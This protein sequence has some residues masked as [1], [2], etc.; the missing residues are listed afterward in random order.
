MANICSFVCVLIVAVDVAAGVLSIEAE[1]AKDEVTHKRL[2]DFKC[3]E[4][5]DRAFKFGLAAATL[6]GLAHI[7]ED[8]VGGCMC[9][10]FTEE[11]ERSSSSRQ[12]WF[13]CIIVSWIVVAIGFPTLV[14]GMLENS[15]S[16]GSCWTLPHHFLFIGGICCFIHGLL[17]VAFYVSASVSFVNGRIHGPQ[18]GQYP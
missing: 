14:V 8:L 11:L 13:A 7:T 17:C 16:K 15:K 12:L 6:L 9:M 2:K 3:E 10:C 4:P 5:N 1:I 18:E